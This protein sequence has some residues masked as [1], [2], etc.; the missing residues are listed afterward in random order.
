MADSKHITRGRVGRLVTLASA[1]IQST[2][3]K[4]IGRETAVALQ[5]TA[6]V[7]GSLRGLAT[8]VGQMTSYVDGLAPEEQSELYSNVLG[9]LLADAPSSPPHRVRE[10]LEAELRAPLNALFTHWDDNPIASASI[11]QV[12]RAV[13]KDGRIVA[14]KVQHPGIEEAF[15]SDLKN[16]STLE[17]VAR[18]FAGRKLD[19]KAI[20]EVLCTRF[21]E[22]LDY[23]QEAANQQAFRELHHDDPDVHV[24]LVVPELSS[25]RVLTSEFVEGMSLVDAAN[26][27]ESLRRHYAETLWRFVVR[28]NYIGRAFNADPHPGNYVFRPDGRVSFLDFGCVQPLTDHM[29]EHSLAQCL[30]ALQGDESGFRQ[31]TVA[32]YKMDEPLLNTHTRNC[33]E[34]L[35][36]SPFQITRK[37]ARDLWHENLMVAKNAKG[38]SD[39]PPELPLFN[40]L[41]FGFYSVLARLNVRVDYASMSRAILVTTS[42]TTSLR[43]T[44]GALTAAPM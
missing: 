40:R 41:Q 34:P 12:H 4:L 23:E 35:F 21:R 33:Y 44:S 22:E 15:E 8:K 13:L 5:Q 42:R 39:A 43:S 30:A 31:A 24:P 17:S 29:H 6:D 11:G 36:C 7:L 20:V 26:Q 16:I 3:G 19:T 18:P 38:R 28:G 27:D 14:V 1:G 10:T 32:F 9:K 2:A 37:Y 25:R